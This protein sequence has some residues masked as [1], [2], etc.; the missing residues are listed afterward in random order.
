MRGVKLQ[1]ALPAWKVLPG[2]ADGCLVV[3]T[4]HLVAEFHGHSIAQMP[5]CYKCVGSCG[6]GLVV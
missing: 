4:F 2:T 5:K 6:D 3:G 1:A